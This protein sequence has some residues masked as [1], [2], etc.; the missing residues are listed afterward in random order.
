M[1]N[2]FFK[3]PFC[4]KELPL[5][6]TFCPYCV[7]KL[8]VEEDKK[9]ESFV[10]KK[11]NWQ[12]I[13][14]CTVITAVVIVILSV[15][16]DRFLFADLNGRTSKNVAIEGDNKSNTDDKQ[17]DKNHSGETDYYDT[18]EIVNDTPKETQVSDSSTEAEAF[19]TPIET[20]TAGSPTEAEA[21]SSSIETEVSSIPMETTNPIADYTFSEGSTLRWPV[22][23]EIVLEYSMDS[24]IF[25][26]SLNL[27]KCNPAINISSEPGSSVI[28][29]ADGIVTDVYID[30][31][32]GKTVSIAIG[33]SYVTTYALLN[34]VMVKNGDKVIAGQVLGTV[35]EPTACYLE[36]GPNLYFMLTKD[37]KPLDPTNY[38]TE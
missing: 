36:E 30:N 8:H 24:T 17:S 4:G 6:A 38:L 29:S 35:S 14:I 18:N 20:E 7:H 37:N 33:D 16:S 1:E 15:I 10:I 34:E 22:K 12:S 19:S 3:C 27:Y 5:E 26:R 32:T 13:L 11:I 21:S 31:D 25:F 28:A 9:E 23:G 2:N